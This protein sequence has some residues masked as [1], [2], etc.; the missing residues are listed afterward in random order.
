M[1]NIL[2]IK[3]LEV[4]YS[5]KKVIDHVSLAFKKQA[6]T[7]IIGPSGCGKSTLLHSLNGLLLENTEAQIKGSALFNNIRVDYE[8]LGTTKGLSA[9]LREEMGIVFQQPIPFPLS[10]KKNMEFALN[11]RGV[12]RKER[13]QIIEDCLKQVNL[14]NEVKEDFHKSAMKLSGGQQQR[15]CIARALTTKPQVLLLD[16]PCSAL[17][18]KNIE[19][20]ESLLMELK[21]TYTIVLVT[22]NIAQ[23]KRIA[24]H[25][26]FILEGQIVETGEA[27]SFFKAPKMT[28]TQQYLSG[29]FG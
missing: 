21:K 18:V 2:E 23:A 15:L 22:H 26:V 10:I 24:D 16:E 28:E 4:Y 12:P 6:I 5:R 27:E 19:I 11:Y 13:T 17:D 20:I 9:S 29:S 7:A 14:Y 3:D 8:N 25:V 1:E